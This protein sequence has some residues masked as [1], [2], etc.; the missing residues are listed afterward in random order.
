MKF[1][2]LQ[3]I[4]YLICVFKKYT[5]I[6]V[7][8]RLTDYMISGCV[9]TATTDLLLYPIDTIK[10]TQQSTRIP[11]SFQN[12]FK[13]ITL[14]KGGIRNFFNG[15]LGYAALDGCSAAIFFA[16]YEEMKSLMA[17][18]LTGAALGLSAY[19]SAGKLLTY[20]NTLHMCYLTA[21]FT[22]HI[23]HFIHYIY[24]TCYYYSFG[25]CSK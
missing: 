23:Y 1:Y 24:T 9:S 12:A 17:I 10:V 16:V 11:I 2:T 8:L 13:S 3:I 22:Y 18:K 7:K 20:C 15:A 19:P 25:I 6:N 14:K 4:F 5:A 21:I